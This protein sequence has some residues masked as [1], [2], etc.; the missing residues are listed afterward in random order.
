[1][2]HHFR[3]RPLTE[4]VFRDL[5]EPSL[6]KLYRIALRLVADPV[7]AEDLVQELVTRLWEKPGRLSGAANPEAWLI[8]ALYHLH[9]DWIRHERRRPEGA[10]VELNESILG[11]E[12]QSERSHFEDAWAMHRIMS[13]VSKLPPSQRMVV[14][15]H[16]LEGYGFAEIAKALGVPTGTVKSRV[17]RAHQKLREAWHGNPASDPDVLSDEVNNDAVS[18]V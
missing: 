3:H 1:M 15:L 10:A 7:G 9:I 17:G 14:I 8:R 6:E 11:T 16:D 4:E 12:Q 13:L 2:R 5:V 18:T